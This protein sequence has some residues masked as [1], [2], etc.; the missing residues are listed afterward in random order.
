M[1]RSD[2]GSRGHPLC[3]VVVHGNADAGG[4]EVPQVPGSVPSSAGLT[5]DRHDVQSIVEW[6]ARILE[7][8][9]GAGITVAIDRNADRQPMVVDA[10]RRCRVGICRALLRGP[11]RGAHR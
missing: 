2:S 1:A 5:P 4:G 9:A 8:V 7:I 3:A 11:L 10:S 6:R